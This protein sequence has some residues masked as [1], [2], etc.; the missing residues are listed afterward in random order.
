ME[1]SGLFDSMEDV[2]R[3]SKRSRS[4]VERY[5]PS[6]DWSEYELAQVGQ[7][8]VQLHPE[9]KCMRVECVAKRKECDSLREKLEAETQRCA[10]LLLSKRSR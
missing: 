6:N 9:R 4:E 2:V 5:D 3:N 7:R 1:V 8:H 10:D